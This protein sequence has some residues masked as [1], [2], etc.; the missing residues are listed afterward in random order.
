MNAYESLD[1]L[2][3]AIKDELIEKNLAERL[4]ELFEELLQVVIT[5]IAKSGFVDILEFKNSA[6]YQY[7]KELF[8]NSF[9]NNQLKSLEEAG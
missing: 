7:L 3:A 2:F 4:W 5:G 1:G 8:E 9:L 6:E